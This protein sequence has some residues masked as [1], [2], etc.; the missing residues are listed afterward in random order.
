MRILLVSI[1]RFTRD[2]L[3]RE[4]RMFSVELRRTL[5][6]TQKKNQ[7][8]QT[9]TSSRTLLIIQLTAVNVLDVEESR[10]REI[11]HIAKI[12]DWT[13]IESDESEQMEQDEY[14]PNDPVFAQPLS[15]RLSSA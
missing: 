12:L 2:D 7:I 3:E 11:K 5:M 4:R 10:S 8:R 1:S 6:T 15:L 13:N 9:H 14:L